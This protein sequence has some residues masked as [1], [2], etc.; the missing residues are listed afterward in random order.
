VTDGTVP[1]PEDNPHKI[2]WAPRKKSV[3]VEAAGSTSDADPSGESPVETDPIETEPADDAADSGRL[4]DPSP[5]LPIAADPEQ[6]S[7]EAPATD[8]PKPEIATGESPD[9]KPKKRRVN[10]F[11][12]ASE[13]FSVRG[14]LA[15]SSLFV[16][17]LFVCLLAVDLIWALAISLLFTVAIS[18]GHLVFYTR[19]RQVRERV[20]F[21]IVAIGAF[22]GGA[23]V[24]DLQ[25]THP[26]FIGQR[27]FSHAT[28]TLKEQLSTDERF[29]EVKVS[30]KLTKIRVA[31]FTGTVQ[32]R[33]HLRALELLAEEAGFAVGENEVTVVG[34]AAAPAQNPATE[35]TEATGSETGSN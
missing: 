22:C 1:E 16:L 2:A 23:L 18:T 11:S 35:E 31:S 14:F 6:A 32:K 27:E 9:E 24:V 5:P 7:P 21:G 15:A 19:D 26:Y 10:P 3:E 17:T 25:L 13:F 20:Y 4:N 28:K 12:G 33:H 8:D 30:T 34:E 29:T